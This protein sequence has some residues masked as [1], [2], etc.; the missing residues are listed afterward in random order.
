[1][2]LLEPL[3][4]G[5]ATGPLKFHAD[6]IPTYGECLE[7]ISRLAY[8]YWEAGEP[9]NPQDHWLKAEGTLFLGS[10]YRIYVCYGD[11]K[12]LDRWEVKV[13]TPDGLKNPEPLPDPWGRR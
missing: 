11:P 9:G 1:M 12:K 6:G 7:L 13:V 10:E 3:P 4:T 8:H 5:Y 2:I